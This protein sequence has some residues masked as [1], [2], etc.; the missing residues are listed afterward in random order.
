MKFRH[1]SDRIPGLG[2]FGCSGSFEKVLFILKMK[3]QNAFCCFQK[4][5]KFSSLFFLRTPFFLR[6]FWG[7]S[8]FFLRMEGAQGGPKKGGCIPLFI[9]FLWIASSDIPAKSRDIPPK[10]LV[11]LC[12][13]GHTKLFGPHPFTWKTPTRPENIRTK[14]FGFGFLFLP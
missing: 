11:S 8:S 1:K 10:S 14:K 5:L 3:L 13:K 9:F 2:I 7:Q 6:M 4:T 12:F